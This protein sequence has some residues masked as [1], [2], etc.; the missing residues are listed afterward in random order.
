MSISKTKEQFNDLF[1]KKYNTEPLQLEP[2]FNTE[3]I[4]I[5][6]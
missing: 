1:K 2:E 4:L 5:S 6:Q 3:A